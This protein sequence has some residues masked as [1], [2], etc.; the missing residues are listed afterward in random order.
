MR[1]LALTHALLVISTPL[2]FWKAKWRHY[3]KRSQRLATDVENPSMYSDPEGKVLILSDD[4]VVYY[5]PPKNPPAPQL[6]VEKCAQLEA[7]VERIRSTLNQSNT[8]LLSVQR[9]LAKEELA[10]ITLPAK[11]SP[12]RVSPKRDVMKNCQKQP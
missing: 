2:G 8:E 10:E 5:S 9:I 4:K 3:H 1:Q 11:V 12:K 6:G 7:H